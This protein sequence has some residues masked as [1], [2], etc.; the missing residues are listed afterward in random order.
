MKKFI[1]VMTAFLLVGLLS[2]KNPKVEEAT[3]DSGGD[4]TKKVQQEEQA[5]KEDVQKNVQKDI[6]I[7]DAD[8]VLKGRNSG[9]D[10]LVFTS[11]EDFQHFMVGEWKSYDLASYAD[12]AWLSIKEDG[13]YALKIKDPVDFE[14]TVSTGKYGFLD[15]L[16]DENGIGSVISF[17]PLELEA[18]E[19]KKEKYASYS[20]D[21]DYSLILKTICDDEI[22]MGLLQV[23]NGNTMLF[24]IFKTPKHIFRKPTDFKTV[25][26]PKPDA[27]FYAICYKRDMESDILWLDEV[28]YDFRVGKILSF[29]RY[30]SVP[31]HTVEKMEIINADAKMEYM[32]VLCYVVTDENAEIKH[33]E[34]IDYDFIDFGY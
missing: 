18:S 17:N 2:C 33:F 11:D 7:S 29:G 5:L 31:Y 28:E 1:L 30:E 23:N 6:P 12:M 24:D 26:K 13:S 25:E 14:E 22:L 19:S 10:P 8:Q 34:I 15:L 21:G 9:K 4:S 20:Y 16:E 27:K 3:K 32:G